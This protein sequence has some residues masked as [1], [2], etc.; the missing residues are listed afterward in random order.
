[1]DQVGFEPLR[2]L[3][4]GRHASRRRRTQASSTQRATSPQLKI[5]A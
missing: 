5:A 1:V 4:R 2:A 3:E